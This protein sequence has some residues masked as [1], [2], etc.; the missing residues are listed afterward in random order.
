MGTLPS[1]LTSVFNN[2]GWFDFDQFKS[3][4]CLSGSSS[5]IDQRA[6]VL[7]SLL[8]LTNVV[9]HW[10]RLEIGWDRRRCCS[11]RISDPSEFVV[12][13]LLLAL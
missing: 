10:E 3:W 11:Q 12:L 6:A 9:Q 13:S 2:E 8:F 4:D 5:N 1:H 7:A